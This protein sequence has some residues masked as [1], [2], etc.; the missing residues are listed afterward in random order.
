MTALLAVSIALVVGLGAAVAYGAFSTTPPTSLVATD[1]QVGNQI[2]L[3]WN[4]GSGD[5]EY[6]YKLA[7][8]GDGSYVASTTVVGT[9]T[10]TVTNTALLNG[11]LYV[12]RVGNGTNVAVSAPIAPT[13]G[14]APVPTIAFDPVVIGW[15]TSVPTYTVSASD[16][17][18]IT[19][20]E[21]QV[22]ATNSPVTITGP[23]GVGSAASMPKLTAGTHIVYFRATDGAGNVSAWVAS[24]EVKI[25]LAEPNKP[26]ISAVTAIAGGEIKVTFGATDPTPGS[27]VAIYTVRMS[28]ESS[29]V[30]FTAVDTITS[31]ATAGVVATATEL[32]DG[33][34][35]YF[36]VQ[37][38][39]AAGQLSSWSTT[40]TP[41][42]KS[43]ATGPSITVDAPNQS[44]W[45]TPSVTTTITVTDGSSGVGV[46]EYKLYKTNASGV[47]TLST[48]TTTSVGTT[49]VIGVAIPQGH[50][51]LVVTATDK[52]GNEQVAPVNNTYLTDN[53]KPV[54]TITKTDPALGAGGTYTKLPGV[55]LHA[56]DAAYGAP[57]TI[58]YKWSNGTTVTAA[59]T[60]TVA[61]AAIDATSSGTYTLTAWANDGVATNTGDV[62][63]TSYV[64]V[65]NQ[66]VT[67]LKLAGTDPL[68]T[69]Y[70]TA[71]TATIEATT[72]G[73][74]P[75]ANKFYKYASDPTTRTLSGTDTVGFLVKEGVQTLTVWS[76]DTTGLVGAQVSYTYK[77]DL[78]KPVIDPTTVVVHSANATVTIGVTDTGSGLASG[79]IAKFTETVVATTSTVGLNAKFVVPWTVGDNLVLANAKDAA[80]LDATP[81]YVHVS[82]LPTYAVT[83][84]TPTNGTIIGPTSADYGTN[85]VYTI[86]PAAGYH[87]VGVT[88]NGAEQ[89]ALASYTVF[90]VQGTH[91]IAATFAANVTPPPSTFTITGTAG[92]HGSLSIAGAHTVAAGSNLTVNVDADAGYHIADVL[93]GG[94][95][96]G[97][98]HSYTFTNV[99]ANNTISATFAADVTPPPSTFTITGTAGANGTMSVI[100]ATSVSAGSNLTV[101]MTPNTYYAVSSVL[102]D[103]VS[104]G[105]V[106][107]YTFSN[108][109]ANH[110]ISVTFVHSAKIWT[111]LSFK[112]SPYTSYRGHKFVFTGKI[113]PSS[114]A[115]G[116]RIT[117]WMRKSGQEWRKLGTVYTNGYDNYSYTLYNGSRT[118]GKYYVRAK[119]AGNSVYASCYSP[120]KTVYIK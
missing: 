72:N 84:T 54:T 75:I 68:L 39:D 111:A 29:G 74:L 79:S 116:T 6:S 2:R 23:I 58:S 25:D 42:V 101:I 95:S 108:V 44:D 49:Q 18:G 99:A 89:G 59:A 14:T 78:T 92:T 81:T 70:N 3:T 110:T 120:Y 117:I 5:Y 64:V 36:Q 103:G 33:T 104:V 106:P 56:T 93:V 114:M 65:V 73:G 20:I 86:T 43:D 11:T 50:Y 51:R 19:K 63:T 30:P 10:V 52:A 9:T 28:V 48:D 40:S 16:P 22:D 31:T 88:D 41:G 17:S 53:S 27:G 112:S 15:Y 47:E 38:A 76:V 77:L 24:G 55:T 60:D 66:P 102:V 7:S 57:L 109:A 61:V 12:F 67:T 85:A 82:Y 45:T 46:I 98:V 113:S 71:T 4:G 107:A 1:T 100:G 13:D 97:A 115:S 62:L 37:A 87:V 34:T 90:N 118:H 80:S 83:I 26:V 119:Y 69:W 35:Y 91:T 94:V 32:V 105:A 96:V 8:A 21:A